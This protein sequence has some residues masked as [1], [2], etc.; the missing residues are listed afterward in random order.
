MVKEFI[1]NDRKLATV[2]CDIPMFDCP[3]F[4]R[5]FDMNNKT[6]PLFAT[7]INEKAGIRMETVPDKIRD[8]KAEVMNLCMNCNAKG[9]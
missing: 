3:V 5:V 1:V 7:T 9:R 2:E 8:L 4:Q 6:I